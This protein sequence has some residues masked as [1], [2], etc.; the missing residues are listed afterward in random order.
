MTETVPEPALGA[1]VQGR[2]YLGKKDCNLAGDQK[3][4]DELAEPRFKY[5]STGKKQAEVEGRHEKARRKS[6]N[7]ADAFLLTLASEAIS[8]SNGTQQ[9]KSWAEPL[10]RKIKGIV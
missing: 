1:V 8:L 9:R 6:P 2:G 4:V 5:T 3:L 10:R 7:R